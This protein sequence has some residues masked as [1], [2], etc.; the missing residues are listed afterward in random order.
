MKSMAQ[1]H[2]A[3]L[4]QVNA[5]DGSGQ[6]ETSKILFNVDRLLQHQSVSIRLINLDQLPI[7]STCS[8]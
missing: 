5:F 8:S 2:K 1:E 7:I 3:E 6:I 4:K